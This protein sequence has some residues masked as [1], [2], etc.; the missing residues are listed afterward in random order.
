MLEGPHQR[1]CQ[2]YAFL[3]YPGQG[4]RWIFIYLGY[5][6]TCTGQSMFHSINGGEVKV[7]LFLEKLDIIITSCSD[8]L[9]IY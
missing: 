1:K 7:W 2:P 9:T 8:L 6:I 3:H 5:P 4:V